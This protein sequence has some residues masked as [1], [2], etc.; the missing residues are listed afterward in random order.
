MVYGF[1]LGV[2]VEYD[3]GKSL[4]KMQKMQATGWALDRKMKKK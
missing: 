2:I 1:C 4:D 3:I